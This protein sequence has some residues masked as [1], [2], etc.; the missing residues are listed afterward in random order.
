MLIF[1]QLKKND[2]PIRLL[3]VAVFGGFALLLVG[4]WWVQVVRGGYYETKLEN[5]SFRTVR[6]PAPRGR[7]LDRNRNPLVENQPAYN[8]SLYLE[9]LSA[10]FQTTFNAQLAAY[11][12]AKQKLTRA[13]RANLARYTRYAVA[14]N[15]V[16]RVGAELRQPLVLDPGLF[17]KH[18]EQDLALPLPV[19][20]NLNPVQIAKLQETADLPAGLDLDIQPV[21]TYPNGSTAAHLLGYVRRDDRSVEGEE[22]FY[23]HRLPDY[24]GIVGVEAAFDK[25]LSGS[26]GQKNMLVNNFG[27][28]QSESIIT[29]VEPGQNVVLTIDLDIQ[30]AAQ[31]ALQI[32]GPNTRGAAVVLDVNNGDLLAMAS[33]PVFDPNE[34]VR[35]LSREQW[36][37][38]SDENLRPQIN[39]CTQ[40]NY[41]PGSIF[42]IIVA[43]AALETGMNPAQTYTVQAD[44]EHAGH[45]C[46]Y[47][48]RRKIADT[49]APGNYDFKRAFIHSS[50]AYFIDRGLHAGIKSIVA[51]GKRLHLGERTGL[52]TRQE[53]KGYFPNA[54][55]VSFA[56]SDGNTA[57]TC[58]GQDPV[59]VTPLQMAVMTAAVANG[60]KVLWPRIIDRVE[61]QDALSGQ[62]AQVYPRA[63]VRDQLGVSPRSLDILRSAMLADVEDSEGT[64]RAAQVP[65][66]RV[67]G[68][69]GTAQVMNER[70]EV[71]DHTTW[72]T[73][74]APFENPRYAVVV[75]I[76]SGGSGG[77]T[78]A[79]IAREIYLAIQQRE[80]QLSRPKPQTL[81]KADAR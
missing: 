31:K 69:T 10:T 79:P 4:L 26:A 43:L 17:L 52:T 32:F 51:I 46:I 15:I 74:Y 18:Y 19:L 36:Q 11:R 37:S 59:L 44:P 14:S 27:Y 29:P 16:A 21:R 1:D 28:H 56:W 23:N 47:V 70:N 8:L 30:Q 45:G 13:Q 42:K 78:C 48:G 60:G 54:E 81:A 33:S 6:V 38:L 55:R 49:A 34:F 58:I 5:Q 65:G 9:E 73:S 57:N 53:V 12:K 71:T 3:A 25:E 64:G 62:A 66:F 39:R 24:R 63:Q 20:P 77:G 22:P 41:A 50:N 68:K 67:C 61:P 40:E 75:M 72:F 76:E 2:P 7:I 80:Q 35:G